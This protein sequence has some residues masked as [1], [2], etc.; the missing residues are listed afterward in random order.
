MTA[1]LENQVNSDIKPNREAALK[2]TFVSAEH[3]AELLQVLELALDD[4]D[5][6]AGGECS[7]VNCCSHARQVARV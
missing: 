5:H 2:T 3:A 1:K 4:L 6:V 7:C